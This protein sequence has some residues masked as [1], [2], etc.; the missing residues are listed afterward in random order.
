MVAE[1]LSGVSQL[2]DAADPNWLEK[3]DEE[4]V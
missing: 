4:N 1:V 2:P 3:L